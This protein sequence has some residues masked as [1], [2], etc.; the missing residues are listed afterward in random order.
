[1]AFLLNE[2]MS[3]KLSGPLY[4]SPRS[5]TIPAPSFVSPVQQFGISLCIKA[6]P[7]NRDDIRSKVVSS[8]NALNG[9]SISIKHLNQDSAIGNSAVTKF[10]AHVLIKYA[11]SEKCVYSTT[12]YLTDVWTHIVAGL[13]GA[14]GHVIPVINGQYFTTLERFPVFAINPSGMVVG[15]HEACLLRWPD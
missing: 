7:A 4:V 8:M 3:C 6:S 2:S 9:F 5:A 14:F 13:N 15:H 11:S 1:M 10:C 12:L